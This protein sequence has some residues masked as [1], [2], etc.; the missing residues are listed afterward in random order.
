MATS[1]AI[2]ATGKSFIVYESADGN[3]WSEAWTSNGALGNT[4]DHTHT[5]AL[6]PSTRY[7]KFFFDGTYAGYYKDISVTECTEINGPNSVDF[8]TTDAGSN[9]TNKNITIDWYNVN[10]LTL[11]I[12]GTNASQFSVSPT[13]IASAKDSYAEKVPVTISYKHDRGG[14]DAA[15][16]VISDGVTSKT[17]GLSGV[18]Q[19]MT[20]SIT[21][22]EN[23]SPLSRG[24]NVTDPATAPVTLT[25]SSSATTIVDIEGNILKPLKKGNATITA[26]FDGTPRRQCA[27]RKGRTQSV[28]RPR[29]RR[30]CI[31][32]CQ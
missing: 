32:S 7:L 27:P 6:K 1:T 15:N 25:Y 11:N 2:G 19:K 8:G 29:R 13:S 24:E 17:I 10:P 26:S 3:S 18:T 14:N 31:S 12:T 4:S 22:K 28:R 5:Q 30:E 21:W 16:L 20:P 9:A 23:L